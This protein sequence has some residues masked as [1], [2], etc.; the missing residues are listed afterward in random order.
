MSNQLLNIAKEYGTPVYAYSYETIIQKLTELKSEIGQYENC[1]FL[2]AVKANHNPHIVKIIV[3]NGF[4]VDAVSLNEAKTGLLVG[5]PLEKIMYTENNI[6]DEEMQEAAELGILINFN[7][8]QRLERF[9][10]QFPGSRVSVRFNP[11]VGAASHATNITGGPDSKFGIAFQE[12]E[13]VKTIAK[14]HNLTIV[15]VHQHIGSGWL[16]LEEPLI[17]L[18]V[19]LDIAKQFDNLEFVD[20]GGGFGVPYKPDQDRLDMKTLGAAFKEKMDQFNLE[21][22]GQTSTKK[23]KLRFEP[24]RYPIAEAGTLIC[25]VTTVKTTPENKTFIGTNTGMNHLIR[26]AL[27]GS[28]HPIENLTN[29]DGATKTYDIV[30]NICESADFFAK[31]R[32]IPETK[33]DDYLAIKIAGAYGST[34]SSIFHLRSV[35]AEILYYENGDTKL[36]KP[37]QTFE[38]ITS[39]YNYN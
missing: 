4:G 38:E 14:K 6:S 34:M 22:Y 39:I 1:E 10:Q 8:L 11:N 9:G 7:S 27:Y 2:Y 25:Q 31:D 35:P 29:P 33:I 13:Q 19:I 17:A 37:T 16:K 30:G 32:A 3:D 12:I 24:G 23:I 18:D 26:P 21:Y 20:F 15:G 36:I 28:Y 5:C